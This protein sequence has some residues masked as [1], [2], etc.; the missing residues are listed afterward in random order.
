M[1]DQW[2]DGPIVAAVKA[3]ATVAL[4]EVDPELQCERYEDD[5]AMY[6]SMME[7]RGSELRVGDV[8]LLPFNKTATIAGVKT[9]RRFASFIMEGEGKRTVLVELTAPVMID[10]QVRLGIVQ[11]PHAWNE[12]TPYP[13]CIRCGCPRD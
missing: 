12:N 11:V 8:L 10:R 6:G 9:G 3:G 7:V 13:H 2:M 4:D 5:V 1:Q